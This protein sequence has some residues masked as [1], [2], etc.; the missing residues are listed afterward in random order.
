MRNSL[1]W[2]LELVSD[3]FPNQGEQKI[4]WSEAGWREL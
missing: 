1:M 2:M 4:G 3:K